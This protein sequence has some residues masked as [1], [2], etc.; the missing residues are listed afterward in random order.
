MFS[1]SVSF[2]NKDQRLPSAAPASS[3]HLLAFLN[4]HNIKARDSRSNKSLEARRRGDE[5]PG[6]SLIAGSPVKAASREVPVPVLAGDPRPPDRCWTVTDPV[7][8]LGDSG[9]RGEPKTRMAVLPCSLAGHSRS[10]ASVPYIRVWR[11]LERRN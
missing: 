6:S 3:I 7:T 9:R 4:A 1:A 10:H 11:C 5:G 8:P 2:R